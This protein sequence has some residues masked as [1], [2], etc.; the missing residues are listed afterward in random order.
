MIPDIL[1]FNFD[2]EDFKKGEQEFQKNL[3][4]RQKNCEE[5]TADKHFINFYFDA[6]FGNPTQPKKTQP[7]IT[8]FSPTK[9]GRIKPNSPENI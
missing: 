3:I 4:Q 7:Q 5:E 9:Y 2:E 8:L 6:N 1:S